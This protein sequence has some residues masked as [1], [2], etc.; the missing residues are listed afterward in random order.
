MANQA[1]EQD[2]AFPISF[3]LRIIYVLAEGGSL[4]ADL[5]RILAARGVTWTLMQGEAKPAAKYGRFGVR[6]TMKN[7]EQMHRTYE[8]IGKLG[9]VKTVL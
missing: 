9:C 2:I 7:R 5:E 8:D 4:R 6:L 1:G 3:D